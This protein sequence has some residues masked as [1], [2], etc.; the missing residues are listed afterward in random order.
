M[1]IFRPEGKLSGFLNKLGDLM[2]L[3]IITIACCLPVVTAGAAL[4]ALYSQTLK[5][6]KNEEGKVVSG[7]FHAFRENFR[8]ATI[9]WGIGGGC[10]LFIV[11]DLYLLRRFDTGFMKAYQGVLLFILVLIVMFCMYLFPVLARFEN[12]TKNTV[13]NA[14]LF[15]MIHFIKSFFMLLINLL[16]VILTC[17]TLRFLFLDVLLGISGTAYLTSI[18]YRS[19]FKKFESE[20]NGSSAVCQTVKRNSQE[21]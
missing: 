5:M 16:P 12:T 14:V 13:K 20:S 18:Y 9:L 19:L 10:T 8:Q 15:C 6:V 1:E 4:T 7:Y 2:V 21:V 11:L 3:N 17:F